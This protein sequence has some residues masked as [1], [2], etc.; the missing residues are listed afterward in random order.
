MKKK[1]IKKKENLRVNKSKAN[2]KSASEFERYIRE[3]ENPNYKGLV[4]QSLPEKPTPTE[5]AKYEICQNIIRYKRRKGLSTEGLAQK[6]NLTSGETQEIL[7]CY[8][9]NF[10]LDRLVNYAS[11]IFKPLTI[12]VQT[13]EQFGR[14]SAK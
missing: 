5:K 11:Q 14:L 9:N 13:R 4:S 2:S 1:V 8:I 6:I 3:I 7:F 10:T 12:K